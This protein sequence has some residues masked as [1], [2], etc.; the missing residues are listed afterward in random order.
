MADWETAGAPRTD[1]DGWESAPARLNPNLAA[2]GAKA[3]GLQDA[4]HTT[5]EFMS[6]RDPGIDYRTGVPKAWFRA[7][8]SRM[9]NDA[10]K[11][12][13]LDRSVGAGQ[14]GKDSYGAYFIK[15]EGL[16]RLGLESDLPVSMDEQT[17]TRYDVADLAG[18][19]PALIGGTAAAM[20]TGGLGLL[21]ALGMTA[22]GSAG[23]KA[24]DEIAKNLSGDQIASAGEVAGEIAKEGALGAV[25]ETTARG[26]MKGGR[27]LLG[28]AASRMTPEKAA[29]AASAQEQGFKIRP[30][31]VT[32]APILARWEGMIRQIFGDLHKEQ[33]QRAAAAGAERLR[34]QQNVSAEEAGNAIRNSLHRQRVN[35]SEAMGKRYS[36]ID[37]LVGNQP[38]IPTAPLVNTAKEL[39]EKLPQTMDGKVVG[40][41]DGLLRDIMAL[42]DAVTVSQAQRLRTLFREASESPDLVPGV[43]KH[44]ARVL[45]QAMED[46]FEQAKQQPK[47]MPKDPAEAAQLAKRIEA[48]NKLRTVDADYAKGIRQFDNNVVTALSRDAGKSGAVDPDMAVDYLIKPERLVRLR[49]VKNLVPEEQWAKVQA[50]HANDLVSKVVQGSNDPLVQVF[51]GRAFRD[52][53]DR[54]GREVLEEVHG[55]QWVDDAYKY[56]NALMLAEKRKEFS[57]GIVAANIALHPLQNLPKLAMLRGLAHLIEQPG[58]FKYLTEGFKFGPGTKEAT[59]ALT[60]FATQVATHAGDETGSA[61]FTLTEPP[62][63][64]NIR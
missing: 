29:L 21:P 64:R 49:L 54:Y 5:A 33:N 56:A 50:A 31:S 34:P 37:E 44:D 12:Q 28:P 48:V 41:G 62:N 1:S 61:K 58:T 63:P 8:F 16:K 59:A 13:F 46:A 23:G 25:G 47:V 38:I 32:D 18:D 3:Q 30:G 17:T 15:P 9:S 11:A 53:L 24:Y 36:E 10:E 57:G 55:K 52:T 60:R 45:K 22:L 42:D 40:G 7:G 14:W 19:A 26:L 27:F 43:H 39:L 20:A 2:Q 6:Q 51:N 4:L 35:F